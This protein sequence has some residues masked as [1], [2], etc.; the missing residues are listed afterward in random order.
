MAK[1]E[2][3]YLNENDLALKELERRICRAGQAEETLTYTTLVQGV[4]FHP[5]NLKYNGSYEIRDW[6][7]PN[8]ALIGEYLSFL[9]EE[10]LRDHHFMS[11]ALV[12]SQEENRP[13]APF[14]DLARSLG[15]LKG[16][17]KQTEDDFWFGQLNKAIA[18]YKSLP[19]C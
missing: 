3:K 14:F 1:G 9:S 6:H 7:D 15:L 12:I 2:W 16:R 11:S 5:L 18:Y 13:C 8:R 10:S 17:N 19:H 4:D